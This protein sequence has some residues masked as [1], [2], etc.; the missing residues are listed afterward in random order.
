MGINLIVR[1]AHSRE[2]VQ[3]VD[4]SGRFRLWRWGIIGRTQSPVRVVGRDEGGDVGE[5]G[6]FKFYSEVNGYL[7]Q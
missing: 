2:L 4:I 1:G 3:L 6:E 7:V 5:S